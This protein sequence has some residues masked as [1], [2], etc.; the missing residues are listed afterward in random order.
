MAAGAPQPSGFPASALHGDWEL[1]YLWAEKHGVSEQLFRVIATLKISD[2]PNLFGSFLAQINSP[3]S[4][5]WLDSWRRTE[6]AAEDIYQLAMAA[7]NDQIQ[8]FYRKVTDKVPAKKQLDDLNTYY[9]AADPC[10]RSRIL[11]EF[12]G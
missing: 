3:S 10:H 4:L 1:A 9:L 5:P 6:G 11:E 2:R 7:R 12:P 8:S